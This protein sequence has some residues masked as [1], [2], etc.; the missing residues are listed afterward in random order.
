[1][2]KYI[3]SLHCLKKK[4]RVSAIILLYIYL[5]MF[6]IIDIN[7]NLDEV[8][9]N[10]STIHELQCPELPYPEQKYTRRPITLYWCQHNYT[11]SSSQSYI[12]CPPRA[13]KLSSDERNISQLHVP[14]DAI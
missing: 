5:F 3:I 1:M 13:D 4:P 6:H 10:S 2:C 7:G 14:L 8:L 9:I 12:S 11:S